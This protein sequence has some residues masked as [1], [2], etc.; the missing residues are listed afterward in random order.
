V[1]VA[2]SEPSAG[3][4]YDRWIFNRA[5]L[6]WAHIALAIIARLLYLSSTDLTHFA[7]WRRSASAGSLM[8]AAIAMMPYLLSAVHSRRLVSHLRVRLCIFR[9][10]LTAGTIGMGYWYVGGPREANEPMT[11]L[12]VIAAQGSLYLWS[13]WWCL[14]KV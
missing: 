13:A 7:Y 11:T 10:V 14:D 9:A 1:A 6:L 4:L 3:V 5:L 8:I 12:Y 2:H